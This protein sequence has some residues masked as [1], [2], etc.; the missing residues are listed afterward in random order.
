MQTIGPWATVA[1]FVLAIGFA[2][3]CIAPRP[4]WFGRVPHWDP[5]LRGACL[6]IAIGIG[7]WAMPWPHRA[8]LRPQAAGFGPDW[9]CP[10]LPGQGAVVCF[11]DE[12]AV[13]SSP[14]GAA[15]R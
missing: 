4:P 11:R 3:L 7:G 14:E 9:H 15:G 10:R 1:A 8:D 6:L 2:W 12:P 5:F 13:L